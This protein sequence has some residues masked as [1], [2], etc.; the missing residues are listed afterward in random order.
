MSQTITRAAR[1]ATQ[2][3]AAQDEFIKLV[4]SL[5]DEQWRMTGTNFPERIN[6]ED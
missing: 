2:F 6:D 5:S 4:E 1:Y 3:E